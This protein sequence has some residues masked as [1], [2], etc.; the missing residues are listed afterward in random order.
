MNDNI[1]DF[2]KRL[3]LLF[4]QHNNEKNIRTLFNDFF[5]KVIVVDNEE[6]ALQLLEK[7]H[8]DIFICEINDDFVRDFD[9]VQKVKDKY[10]NILTVVVSDTQ[11]FETLHKTIELGINDYILKPLNFEVLQRTM[12]R[13]ENIYNINE[14]LENNRQNL[15][16]LK[17][18]QE[19]ADKSSII[20]KTDKKGYI[21]Y[22]NDNFC[23]ISEY[24]KD[25]LYGQSH[26]I[27][28]HPDNP[29]DIYK[30]MWETISKKKT[31]WSGII[32]NIS[33]SGKAYYVK[34]TIK[35]IL[36]TNNEIIEYIALRDNIS[37]I[38]SDKKQLLDK[39]ESNNLSILILM[40]IEEFDMLS[41]FYN[42]TIV[43]QIEKIFG[44]NLLSYLPGEYIFENVYNLDNGQYALLTEL[45]GFLASDINIET[46]LRKF[47]ENVKKSVLKVEEIEYDVNIALS[48]SYGKFMLY[49]DA[50]SGL[51]EAIS[52]K[53][54]ICHSNDFSIDDQKEAKKNL[55]IIK[56]VKVALDQ[57]KIISYFQ[58]IINN[59]T[60]EIEKYESLVR[61]IDEKGRVISP[62]AFLNIS[63]R[64][65]YYTK[66]T[67]RV[68]ENSFKMLEY[69]TTK[70][71][72]NLSAIDIEKDETRKKIY[73]L[74]EQYKDDSHRLIFELLEEESVKD[75]HSIKRFIRKVK[76]KG[77]MIAID[78]FGAG[79][80]NFERLLEF[81]PDILK[82]DGSLIKNVLFDEYNR[83]LVST[84]V[85]FSKKQNIKTVA[86]FVENE[87]I[88]NYLNKIG[89]DYSQGYYFG[90]PESLMEE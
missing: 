35:P 69:I 40:Q 63:K 67:H 7:H 88:F 47:V 41:K 1:I 2:T 12:R 23:K 75:L 30:D 82:I 58:P 73:E 71:S 13:L 60:R 29:K 70:L 9:L 39:I 76:S 85:D 59:K 24:S 14:E 49:E 37:A 28:R 61:L 87:E 90:K 72:I 74:L 38:M 86:E 36:D 18:Y 55:E 16:L 79:Y 78:D 80:S 62:F 3:T 64:G 31:E 54:V 51:E 26:N 17:Q 33:K 65:H 52:K 11:S 10:M 5:H 45:D 25:E 27:V 50:K 21:T 42:I 44:F 53:M 43:D 83:N 15:N 66:I 84:I 68:L 34:S 6:D 20:S 8:I 4:F 22:A 46:Y 77:V 19:I 89:V 48:Y 32:K 81:E 57:Y 56:M